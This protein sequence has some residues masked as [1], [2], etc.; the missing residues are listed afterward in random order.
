MTMR[1]T[2]VVLATGNPHKVEELRAILAPVAPDLE[3]VGYDGPSPIED[4]DTFIANALIKAQAAADATGLPSIADDSGISVDAL[5]GAPGIHSARYSGT[6]SDVDNRELLLHRLH[7]VT[8]RAAHFTCAAVLVAPG[9]MPIV[10]QAE[11]PGRVLLEA[12][13]D[14]GFGYDP[15]FQPDGVDG[16]AATLTADQK[17][18][19]SHRGQ[20]FRALIAAIAGD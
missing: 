7:G 3:I 18:A 15:V 17:N 20:A 4:G 16:S 6:G 13:G 12:D 11:W 2:R 19:V 14:G 1:L 9:R 10:R 5:H 8:D